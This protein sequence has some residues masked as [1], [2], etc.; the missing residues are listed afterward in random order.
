M[1]AKLKNL[2]HLIYLKQMY[3][4]NIFYKEKK[5]HCLLVLFFQ[6]DLINH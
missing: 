6:W 2:Q 5:K 1:K 4:T 3:N